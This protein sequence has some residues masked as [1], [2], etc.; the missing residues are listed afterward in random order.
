MR[1]ILVLCIMLGPA[2]L[3]LN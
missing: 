3:P 1:R 2:M